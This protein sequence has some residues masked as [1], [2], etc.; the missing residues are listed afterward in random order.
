[1][2]VEKIISWAIP[3]VCGGVITGLIA[4]VKT[5]RRR[6]DAMQEGVQCLL[7]A[8][9]IRNHDKYV[10]DKNYCPIYAKEALKRA[11]HAYHELHAIDAAGNAIASKIITAD[12]SKILRDGVIE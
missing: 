1:M 5:L 8:E 12:V 2:I 3:F 10:L 11:Y 9:V 7:R 4:Y 6:N